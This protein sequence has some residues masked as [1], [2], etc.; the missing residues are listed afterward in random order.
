MRRAVTLIFLVALLTFAFNLSASAQ[1]G[2]EFEKDVLE[3]NFFGGLGIPTGE[4]TDWSGSLG[5]K[6]GFDAGI[7]IGYFA[8]AQLVVGFNF[9]FSQFS[10]DAQ[11]EASGLKHRLYNPN[12]YVKYYLDLESDWSPYA[13]AHVGVENPKF[14]TFVTNPVHDRYRQV[15][16]D[17]AVAFGLGAGLFYYTSDYSGLFLEVNYHY[18]ATSD[19]EA[20][21]EGNTYTFD[22]NLSAID[23]HAGIRILIGP[24]E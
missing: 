21:Y 20:A 15:S 8:T 19:A 3:V 16:Y 9:T 18:A 12:L 14:T 10:I 5:A 6:S 1:D 13:K 7:D 4:I 24:A 23:I 2:E 11:D 22:D 17:P